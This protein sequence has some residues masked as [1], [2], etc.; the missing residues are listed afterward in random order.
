VAAGEERSLLEMALIENVQREDLNPI[1]EALAYR[2]LTDDFHLTQDDIA[3]AVGKDRATVANFLRLLKLRRCA[4][5]R[6]C[7]HAVDGSC[8]R[9]ARA[10][11]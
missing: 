7:R 10:D 3:A 11:G 1:D 6:G 4:R 9:P 8:A 5:G 2:R